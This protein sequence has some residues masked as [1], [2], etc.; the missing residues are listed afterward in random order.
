M[1]EAAAQD[2]EQLLQLAPEMKEALALQ[3]RLKTELARIAQSRQDEKAWAIKQVKVYAVHYG[4]IYADMY[5][6]VYVCMCMCISC[7]LPLL[8]IV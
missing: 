2:A 6:C 3:Q 5:V 7:M 1:Y 4:H 8:V